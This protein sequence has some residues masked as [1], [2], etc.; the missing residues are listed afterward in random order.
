MRLVPSERA[1]TQPASASTF[2][3]RLTVDCGSW[4]TPHSSATPSSWRSSRR[5]SRRR[6][7][8]PR[9]SKPEKSGAAA[10]GTIDLSGSKDR[11][12]AARLSRPPRRLH[13]GGRPAA[14]HE[15]QL[16]APLA[17]E[18][19]EELLQVVLGHHPPLATERRLDVQQGEDLRLPGPELGQ[20]GL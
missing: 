17:V 18:D 13:G 16:A 20:R 19:V 6:V 4:T 14:L 12:V 1:R 7:G 8:S 11:S 2:R 10:E 9:V 15:Q 5:S 3:C